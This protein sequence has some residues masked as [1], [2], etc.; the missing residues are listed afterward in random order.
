M[1]LTL[2]Q[3]LLLE[4]NAVEIAVRRQRLG[5]PNENLWIF[6]IRVL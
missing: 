4:P 6:S 3:Q 2:T 1:E 5:I